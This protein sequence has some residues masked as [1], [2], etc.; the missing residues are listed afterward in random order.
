MQI[1]LRR[2]TRYGRPGYLIPEES[3]QLDGGK[4]STTTGEVR[5]PANMSL[6]LCYLPWR[7][8]SRMRRLAACIM[9]V[10]ALSR[11]SCVQRGRNWSRKTSV[12]CCVIT[13][14]LRVDRSV[15]PK[16]AKGDS[17][18][19]SEAPPWV[20]LRD[21]SIGSLTLGEPFGPNLAVFED[22]KR[23]ISRI[24]LRTGIETRA[25]LESNRKRAL[26]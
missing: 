10:S 13:E 26:R 20:R 6:S 22:A 12:A 19:Q 2:V 7:S 25:H 14:L 11:C 24:Y 21:G 17:P 8:L 3:R 9:A 23:D 4:R 1:G 16:G 15:R 18:G 5:G